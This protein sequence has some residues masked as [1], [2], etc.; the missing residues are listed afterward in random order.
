VE[1]YSQEGPKISRHDGWFYMTTAVGGT[2]GPPTGHMVISA[3]SRSIHGPWQNSPYNPIVRTV[4]R[5]EPWWSRGHATIV[6]GID[7]RDWMVYH[8]YENG[9]YTLGRQM[10]LDPI[11][12]TADGWFVA[13]GGDLGQPLAKPA[14]EALPHGMALSDGFNGD[15]LGPQ[16][17]FF[18]PGPD[19]YRRLSF[20]DGD[21]TVQG[22]GHSPR[23]SSPL[24]VIAGDR[25]Y[26]FEVEM[27]I[28]P[29]AIGGALLFY[30]DRLYAG[31]GSNGEQ[32]I[33]HR[34]GEDRP[35]S[36]PPSRTGG[37]LWLRVTNNRNILTVHTSQDG[38]HWQKYPVQMDVSG[39]HHN[40]AGGF[41]ALKPAIYAA[42]TGAVTFH[43]FRYRALD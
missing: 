23:D 34:Y 19:E 14:G 32:F 24:T 16:W 21:L 22:K 10:L 7:G 33:L 2:A 6:E 9:Y 31:V 39:Y 40:V 28:A 35:A 38:Q 37:K 25:A 36:L 41:L 11:A 20:K 27:E 12:W 18:K 1:S 15:K 4:S 42:G 13:K 17:A 30:S 3:R 29:G 26:E 5:D 43:H 8:G